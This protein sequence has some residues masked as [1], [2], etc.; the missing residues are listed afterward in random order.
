MVEEGPTKRL[1]YGPYETFFGPSDHSLD[2]FFEE[3]PVIVGLN[4]LNIIFGTHP[5]PSAVKGFLERCVDSGIKGRIGHK[6][7]KKNRITYWLQ[8]QGDE[9]VRIRP[10]RSQRF[11]YYAE[12]SQE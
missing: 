10:P 9:I 1:R 12:G 4:T 7:W 5:H 2:R 6:G 11:S 8:L 3:A